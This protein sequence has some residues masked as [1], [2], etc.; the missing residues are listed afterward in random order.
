MDYLDLIDKMDLDDLFYFLYYRNEYKDVKNYD[1]LVAEA[2][3]MEECK[4]EN[5][6]LK[7]LEEKENV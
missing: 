1:E 5:E 7:Y 3:F 4:K 6:Q 2:E